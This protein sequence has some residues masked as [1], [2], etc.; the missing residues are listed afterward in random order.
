MPTGGLSGTAL[1]IT[2]TDVPTTDSPSSFRVN[3]VM[4]LSTPPTPP[5]PLPLTP[6]AVSSN[7][8]LW[9]ITNN[10]TLPCFVSRPTLYALSCGDT[11]KYTQYEAKSASPP[12][13]G[14]MW[15]VPPIWPACESS[16]TNDTPAGTLVGARK[17]G[18]G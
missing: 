3:T 17:G 16:S 8:V 9:G 18:Q 14:V 15:T 1:S 5:E 12:G 13:G 7:A 11:P 10:N 6:S 2:R 4:K